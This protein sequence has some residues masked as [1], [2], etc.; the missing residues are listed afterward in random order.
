[1]KFL[2]LHG[3]IGNPDNF[4]VQLDPLVRELSGDGTAE[5]LF[6]TGGF[7]VHPHSGF[8]EYFGPGPHYRFFDDQ[9]TAEKAMLERVRDFEVAD[10]PEDT[11]RNLVR[12]EDPNPPPPPP[13]NYALDPLYDLIDAN[14]D[15]EGII[16]YS[17]GAV[18]AGSLLHDEQ[19]RFTE[20]GREKR[21]KCAM[22]FAGWPPLTSDGRLIYGD[23]ID[24]GIDAHSIHV[25][26]ANDPYIAGSMAL[27]NVFDE[28]S[29]ALFDH[30][31][32]HT[33]PRDPRTLRELAKNVRDMLKTA[34]CSSRGD[35]E[36]SSGTSSDIESVDSPSD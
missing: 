24:E 15:I 34:G 6:A 8:E 9:G 13:I 18:L 2:C 7:E 26:G 5:F 1:M 29:A 32:G 35:R 31:K 36:F 4:S 16:G 28:D 25:I 3:A 14:P 10:T 30:G 27:Y 22:F 33:I 11:I 20:E 23:E 19:R 17:E 21:L 12:G